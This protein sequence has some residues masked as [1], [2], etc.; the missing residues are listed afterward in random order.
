MVPRKYCLPWLS[1]C[2][3]KS[4]SPFDFCI[5]LSM[6]MALMTMKVTTEAAVESAEDWLKRARELIRA[7]TAKIA[8]SRLCN[9]CC[10]GDDDEEEDEEARTVT[11]MALRPRKKAVETE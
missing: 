4:R 7:A 3:M 5:T 11:M 6:K 9:Y 2:T 10:C 8:E 1:F